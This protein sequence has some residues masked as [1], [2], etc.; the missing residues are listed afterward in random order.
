MVHKKLC[1]LCG[2]YHVYSIEQKYID[3]YS[4]YERNFVKCG[5]GIMTS[6]DVIK[7]LKKAGWVW[8]LTKGSH[9]QFKHP[10]RQNLITVPHPK[11][12]IKPGTLN[13]ILK[14]A[15]LK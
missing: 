11:K 13:R 4:V 1:E 6:E 3:V 7:Q 10:D 2:V 14:D 5:L 8:V 12:D 9:H 15:G